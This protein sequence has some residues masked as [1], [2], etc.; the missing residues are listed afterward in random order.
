MTTRTVRIYG[1][2]E[3]VIDYTWTTKKDSGATG[4]D[5][6]K[7]EHCLTMTT[8][9]NVFVLTVEQ[10][11][12]F[13]MQ[14][15]ERENAVLYEGNPIDGDPVDVKWQDTVKSPYYR[16]LIHPPSI[17]FLLKRLLTPSERSRM[18]LEMAT[19]E[20]GLVANHSS[21]MEGAAAV[22]RE[23]IVLSPGAMPDGPVG[24]ALRSLTPDALQLLNLRLRTNDRGKRLSWREVAELFRRQ[25]KIEKTYTDERCRQIYEAALKEYP[26]LGPY[27]D[28]MTHRGHLTLTR[29]KTD[30]E[31]IEDMTTQ[32]AFDGNDV[33]ADDGG[34][35]PG[36]QVRSNPRKPLHLPNSHR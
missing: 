19:T 33:I 14:I 15:S 11:H 36:Y 29:P 24:D 35:S 25:G 1:R 17:G 5:T 18:T 22:R 8:R 12:D 20:R 13:P 23:A 27:I 3:E 2:D 21:H 4:Q 31:E 34:Q 9:T 7:F 32:S 6:V 10:Q 16:Q 28:A 30:K 26:I